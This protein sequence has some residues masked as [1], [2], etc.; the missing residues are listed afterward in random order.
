MKTGAQ[1]LVDQ[2]L[3]PGGTE[4]CG[5]RIF[6][7]HIRPDLDYDGDLK[8]SLCRI[9]AY[10]DFDNLAERDPAEQHRGADRQSVDRSF[11]KDDEAPGRLKEGKAA[12]DQ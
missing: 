9:V 7:D 5:R 11:E 6:L 2:A 12:E 4:G 8:G 1:S 10:A 3:Q